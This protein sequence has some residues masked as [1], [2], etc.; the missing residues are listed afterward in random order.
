MNITWM[1]E[2]IATVSPEEVT[3]I[4]LLL[5]YWGLDF[6]NQSNSVIKGL[7]PFSV[8]IEGIDRSDLD[9]FS[10]LL[11]HTGITLGG[12]STR[13]DFSLLVTTEET[14][15]TPLSITTEKELI[16]LNPKMDISGMLHRNIHHNLKVPNNVD[17]INVHLNHRYKKYHVQWLTYI[18]IQHFLY[19][20]LEDLS[21][22]SIKDYDKLIS[23][24]LNQ[25]NPEYGAIQ[26]QV[27]SQPNR[28]PD[29]PPHLS[30]APKKPTSLIN[31]SPNDSP[32][33][34]QTKVPEPVPKTN[35]NTVKT[36]DPF[37]FAY[38]NSSN[39]TFNPFKLQNNPASKSVINPFGKKR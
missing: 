16:L 20:K 37:K 21:H 9:L 24:V 32:K 8:Y 3:M 28:W 11:S 13:S 22:I 7:D 29:L 30:M 35:F 25:I 2:K 38:V 36:F 12:K 6:D 5:P 18:V 4:K 10:A 31:S 34:V 23:F 1:N 27:G 26:L 14:K 15:R 33:K 19:T 17:S 39:Q